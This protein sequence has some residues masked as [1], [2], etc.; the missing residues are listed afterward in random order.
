MGECCYICQCRCD[1]QR[2]FYS[3]MN[4]RCTVWLRVYPRGRNMLSRPPSICGDSDLGS[5]NDCVGS[6]SDCLQDAH[7]ICDYSWG[8]RVLT[9]KS[10]QCTEVRIVLEDTPTHVWPYMSCLHS[11]DIRAIAR[12]WIATHTTAV[13]TIINNY[14]ITV[15]NYT[16]A[17]I[18]IEFHAH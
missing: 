4:G 5:L 11:C 6:W 13:I 8:L 3:L 17:W 9:T 2:T 18:C 12:S 14:I 1:Y 16:P 15:I 7:I 10:L